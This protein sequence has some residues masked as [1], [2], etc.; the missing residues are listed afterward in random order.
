MEAAATFPPETNAAGRRTGALP[1]V[2]RGAMLLGRSLWGVARVEAA[3][4][5]GGRDA[6]Y[7]MFS[8]IA[9]T[10]ADLLG[11]GFT[12]DGELDPR[13]HE[14]RIANH[15][16][17]LDILILSAC[18]GGRF[19]SRHDIADWPIVG[20]VATRIGTLYVDRDSKGGAAKA[21]RNLARAAREGG[22]LLVF[23]E[24]RTSR[25]TLHPFKKGAF[26]VAHAAHL[27]LRPVVV[28][29][30]DVDEAAWV[31]DMTFL[32]H[33]WQRLSGKRI[34][35]HVRVL[36][37]IPSEGVSSSELA[38]QASEAIAGALRG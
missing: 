34:S 29:Y 21:L 36:A 25:G 5:R 27:P 1:G 38:R 10:L 14:V 9:G 15:T 7:A 16:S 24:G 33:L 22:A 4:R 30:D 6:A 18:G 37:S 19:L 8:S 28:T 17:Y 32:P 13:A 3:H 23:P 35:A 2:A 11:V 31:D 26:V 12:V 20:R